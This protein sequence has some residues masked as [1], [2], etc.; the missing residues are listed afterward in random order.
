M[1]KK[2]ELITNKYQTFYEDLEN[3]YHRVTFDSN[4]GVVVVASTVGGVLF[5]QHDGRLTGS[6]SLELIRGYIENGETPINAAIREFTEE[7][8]LRYDASNITNIVDYGDFSIDSALTN[9]RIHVIGVE[10]AHT[11]ATYRPQAE[12]K[13]AS[14]QWIKKDE[15][16][17]ALSGISDGITLAAIAKAHII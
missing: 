3:G 1:F 5:I 11:D 16:S 14:V 7:S 6:H 10:L 12:E 17:D 8:G 13:I 4:D 2:R 15:V 9:Q